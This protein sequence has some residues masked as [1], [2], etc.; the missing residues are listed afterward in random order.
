[1]TTALEID[2]EA[3]MPNS[4]HDEVMALNA[5]HRSSALNTRG[6]VRTSNVTIQQPVPDYKHQQGFWS[7]C[8]LSPSCYLF[9]GIAFTLAEAATN[10][11]QVYFDLAMYDESLADFEAAM[12]ED[13][14]D[15]SETYYETRA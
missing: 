12:E 7:L 4:K 3:R 11:A 2:R 10:G 6:R 15:E 5:Y 14:S 9:R 1:M 8:T 13:R